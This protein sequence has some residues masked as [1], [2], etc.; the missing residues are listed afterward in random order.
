MFKRWFQCI[1]GSSLRKWKLRQT[2]HGGLTD[3]TNLSGIEDH[4]GEF[5][6]L[7]VVP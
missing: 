6:G 1:M 7:A 3:L 4:L 2:F 5:S